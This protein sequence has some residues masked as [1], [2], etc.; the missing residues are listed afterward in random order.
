MHCMYSKGIFTRGMTLVEL[1]IAIGLITIV[2]G[3]LF[4]TFQF[5]LTLINS[6]KAQAGALAL[7]NEK[8]EYIR[9]LEYDDIGTVGG[10]P[11]GLLAQNSTT[12]LNGIEYTERLLI[13]YV[14]APE[15][16]E[17]AADENS[18]LA[19]Y[20]LVKVEY[21]WVFRGQTNTISLISNIVP[22]GIETTAGGG[23]LTVNVFDADVQPLSG[24][25]VRVVNTN[26]TSTIDTTRLTN[27]NGVAMFSGAPALAGY[28][29]TVT[30]AGYSTD[31]TYTATTSNPNPV[32]LPVAVLEAE[33]STMNFQI[34]E[35]SDLT[36][37]TIGEP[38]T[39]VFEDTFTDASN[40]SASS[41]VT[42]AGGE[43]SL[44]GAPGSYSANGSLYSVAVT[45]ASFTSWDTAYFSARIPTNTN[46]VVHVYDTS[47]STNPV[48]VPDSDL[49]GNASGFVPGTV[50]LAALNPASY[51]SLG[52]GAELTTSDVATTS[53]L[54]EWNIAYIISQPPIAGVPF[55]LQ[56]SK[57]IGTN[58]SSSP[59][60]KY[61]D[62]FTTDGSGQTGI[63][64]LE[65]DTYTVTV[66]DPSYDIAEA[67]SN[68]PYV[69]NPGVDDTLTLTLVP[70][71]TYALRIA[72]ED[73]VGTPI[74]NADLTLSRA[75]FSEDLTSSSCG[76]AFFNS[77]LSTALDYTL[78]VSASGYADRT[79][80]DIAIDGQETL[81][82][83]M[84]SL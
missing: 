22:E 29:I 14:D 3:G 26:G 65:W 39:D 49:P 9:S 23:T 44:S 17:G 12:T 84:T 62:S 16:G 63:E 59:I 58:A 35:L 37:R 45:P 68:I 73:S 61:E 40:V 32:T 72:V 47:S 15:D 53:A 13:Q 83:V 82:V 18:I 64:D 30:K 57:V 4:G 34:D 67:C 21:S 75:G 70:S 60:Y 78:S 69:L 10:I 43:V 50:A 20:K 19:D 36:V 2:F 28:E 33:V 51:P 74:P 42:I 79:I 8:I 52:L 46:L 77:G 54:L 56:S 80:T 38:T 31:G 81:L 41:S 66:D 11:E 1:L 55:T 6:S 76:Q 5:M 25:S 27:A 24:A 48:L 71:V 7:A